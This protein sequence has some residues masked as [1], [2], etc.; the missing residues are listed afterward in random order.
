[1]KTIIV[2]AGEVGCHIALRLSLEEK[3]VIVLDK[4]PVAL[5]NALERV[6]VQSIEASGFDPQALNRI[7][8]EAD[9]ILV[10]VTGSD[11]A[12][13]ITCMY[14]RLLSPESV[15]LARVRNEELA[16]HHKGFSLHSA[17]IGEVINPN[18]ELVK[19]VMRIM[20][21][22]ESTE[23]GM[24]VAGKIRLMS[25]DVDRNAPFAGMTAMQLQEWIGIPSFSIR[26]L[27]KENSL[28][29][30]TGNETIK[31][32]D[33]I[34]FFCGEGELRAVLGSLRGSLGSHV[35][36]IIGGGNVGLR[37][38]QELDRKSAFD[39]RLVEKDPARVA[40]LSKTL[41][42][43]VV[44]HADAADEGFLECSELANVKTIIALT[45]DEKTNILCSLLAKKRGVRQTIARINKL[46]NTRLT[47]SFGLEDV[48]SANGSTLNA[49][50]QRI[51]HSNI[52]CLDGTKTEVIEALT[53]DSVCMV[54]QLLDRLGC[55]K[56]LVMLGVLR[57]DQVI[58]PFCDSVLC[59][60]DRVL[61]ISRCQNA[62]EVEQELM[63]LSSGNTIS[64]TSFPLLVH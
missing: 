31:A 36:L 5:R 37:L 24:F 52:A 63:D 54:G 16:D 56:S 35:I 44:L 45:G 42:R 33:T 3:E 61:L 64:G 21:I 57:N 43:A 8:I 11:T 51:Y 7:G 1:M 49:I 14:G 38:A 12:N 27:V 48:V 58:T 17:N 2:G 41:K 50:L 32:G 4:D 59:P 26:A 29:P 55:D 40:F 30:S 47:G 23:V 15:K 6:D 39:I 34:Y 18:R 22:P 53:L 9:D 28:F 60:G 10:A 19:S 46:A 25:L 62:R 13:L 20:S